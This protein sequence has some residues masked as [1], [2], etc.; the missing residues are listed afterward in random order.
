[1][2]RFEGVLMILNTIKLLWPSNETFKG[3]LSWVTSLEDNGQPSI[4]S[5]CLGFGFF[6]RSILESFVNFSFRKQTKTP[7][8]NK[9]IV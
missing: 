3:A 9:R 4:T 5:I 8:S 1:M 7:K 6:I 2:I